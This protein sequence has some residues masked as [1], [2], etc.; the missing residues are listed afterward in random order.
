M[1]QHEPTAACEAD[2]CYIHHEDEPSLAAGIVCGEC[3]HAYR[4]VKDLMRADQQT[5][6]SV[7]LPPYA[8]VGPVDM[9][10]V[11]KHYPV[12]AYCAHDF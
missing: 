3:G 11:F 5:R 6:L 9:D 10:N 12:C 8:P 4:D 1:A 2:H 7:G